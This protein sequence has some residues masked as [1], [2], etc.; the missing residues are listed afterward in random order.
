M[1]NMKLDMFKN[2]S[3][4]SWVGR[5]ALEL[6]LLLIS[7]P[8]THN[9]VLDAGSGPFEPFYLAEMLPYFA[10][11]CAVDTD[12]EVYDALCDLVERKSIPLE[13]L[14]QI[15]CNKD[16]NG[17]PIPNSDLTDPKL[18][19]LGLRELENAGINPDLFLDADRNFHRPKLTRAKQYRETKITPFHG[20]AGKYARKHQKQFDFV[21]AGVVLLKMAKTMETSE[22]VQSVKYLAG[23]LKEN[24]VLGIG[25]TPAAL[26]GEKGD[27]NLLKEAGVTVTDVVVDNLVQV[28]GALRG[29]YCIRATNEPQYKEHGFDWIG[30]LIRHKELLPSVSVKNETLSPKELF[31]YLLKEND[32]LLLAA[33]QTN[34]GKYDLYQAPKAELIK[35]IP[36][37]RKTISV[38]REAIRKIECGE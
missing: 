34:T 1:T 28:K 25:T 9:K 37:E 13:E 24:G 18:L 15:A 16:E 21:Y 29:G 36:S 31:D 14:A 22:L 27:L 38:I 30:T 12:Q 3:T 11:I 26:Y 35:I 5:H 7:S 23:A 4:F 2:A 6:K 17:F 33:Q 32:Q 19:K 8:R 20:D 10:E